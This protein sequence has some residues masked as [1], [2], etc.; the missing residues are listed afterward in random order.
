MYIIIENFNAL[1]T[2]NTCVL[3][4]TKTPQRYGVLKSVETGCPVE[5]S[6]CWTEE[7]S[8][9]T[10]IYLQCENTNSR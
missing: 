7:P 2:E 1:T 10:K 8:I 9:L 5:R 3:L 4:I 6:C